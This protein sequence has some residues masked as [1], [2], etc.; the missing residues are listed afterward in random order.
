IQF[1]R[2]AQGRHAWS[3]KSDLRSDMRHTATDHAGEIVISHARRTPDSERSG[4]GHSRAAARI[5]SRSQCLQEPENKDRL[6]GI[7]KQAEPLTPI[8]E[9]KQTL[10][11]SGANSR[12]TPT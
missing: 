9:Q 1:R 12:I 4:P 8:C 5:R 7:S 3:S 2:H 10:P 6:A 11:K